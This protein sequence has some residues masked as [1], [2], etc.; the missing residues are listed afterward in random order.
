[1][2]AQVGFQV[3]DTT[4][5][6]VAVGGFLPPQARVGA[7]MP[8]H[9]FVHTLLQVDTLLAQRADNNVSADAG[10]NRHVAQRIG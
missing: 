1:M 3:G 5:V 10:F 2:A 6:D 9:V 8:R 7:E 4:V